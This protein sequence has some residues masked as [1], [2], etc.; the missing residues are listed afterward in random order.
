[1]Q[2]AV[3]ARAALETE[4]R[5]AIEVGQF[6]LYYQPVREFRTGEIV[7]S[8]ALLRWNHPKRGIVAPSEFIPTLESS[9]LIA[10]VGRWVVDEACRQA[11]EWATRLPS[12]GWTAVNVSAAQLRA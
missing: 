8:E 9:G 2:A 4:L 5:R 10:E 1:M 6:L 3:T 12:I 11:A 7:G